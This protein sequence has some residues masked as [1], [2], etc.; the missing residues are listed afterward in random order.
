MDPQS[1]IKISQATQVPRT[2]MFA[3]VRNRRGVVSAVEP[4]DGDRGRLHLVHINYKDDQ[5]PSEER[6]LWERLKVVCETGNIPMG[7]VAARKDIRKLARGEIDIRLMKG[8][9]RQFVGRVLCELAA[10]EF[11]IRATNQLG[12]YPGRIIGTGDQCDELGEG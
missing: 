9:R 7:A 5:F 4:Y 11:G 8:W 10:H 6:L 2:G 3:T 12:D 1:G